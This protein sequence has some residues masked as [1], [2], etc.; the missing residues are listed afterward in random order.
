MGETKSYL[1]SALSFPRCSCVDRDF[2][3]RVADDQFAAAMSRRKHDCQCAKHAV[4]LFR[5]AMRK[6]KAALFVNEQLVKFGRDVRSST[7]ESIGNG[8]EDVLK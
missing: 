4:R 6:E 5:V 2:A 7:T 8:R 1:R 3:P